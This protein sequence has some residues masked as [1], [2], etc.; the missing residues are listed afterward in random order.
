MFIYVCRD[1]SEQIQVTR[2]HMM[3]FISIPKHYG[4]IV[5]FFQSHFETEFGHEKFDFMFFCMP[6]HHGCPGG[7]NDI[8]P[9]GGKIF[10]ICIFRPCYIHITYSGDKYSRLC[11]ILNPIFHDPPLL[12]RRNKI[13]IHMTL[14]VQLNVK[15][16][17]LITLLFHELSSSGYVAKKITR[18]ASGH[19]HWLW[20][21]F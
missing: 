6:G 12:S 5:K 7:F 16:Y 10:S 3:Y 20:H 8:S 21:L 14:P 15:W 1:T 18:K 9:F 17:Y 2:S 11:S 4:T 19:T 13:A